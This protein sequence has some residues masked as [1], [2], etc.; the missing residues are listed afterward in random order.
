MD[1]YK[2]GEG[3]LVG[4]SSSDT[5]RKSAPSKGLPSASKGQRDPRVLDL[6]R[7]AEKLASDAKDA[8]AAGKPAADVMKLSKASD[9]IRRTADKLADQIDK[10]HAPATTGKRGGRFYLSASGNK[11]YIKS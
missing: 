2:T 9:Q 3:G 1:R 5:Y 8:D 10:G 7:K 6:V 11:V 4:R